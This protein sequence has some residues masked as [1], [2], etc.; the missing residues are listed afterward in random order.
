MAWVSAELWK[1]L[2]EGKEAGGAEVR[3]C[4][5]F[6]KLPYGAEGNSGKRTGSQQ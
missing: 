2:P 5:D 3:T 1:G 4:G 6:L